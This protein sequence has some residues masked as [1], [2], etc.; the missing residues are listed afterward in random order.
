MRKDVRGT[1]VRVTI[2]DDEPLARDVLLRAAG[3]WRYECQTAN[4]AEE[5]FF[6]AS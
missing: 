6:E 2:V 4:S 5:L 1:A 3:L